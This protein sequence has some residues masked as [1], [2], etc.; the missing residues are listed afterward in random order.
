MVHHSRK[1]NGFT[2][3]E[4]VISLAILALSLGVLLESQASS[5]SYAGRAR[6]LTV[7]STLARS[8]LVDV[9]L[10]LFDEGFSENEVEE[11]GSFEDEGWSDYKWSYKISPIQLDLNG[12]NAMCAMMGA[13]AEGADEGDALAEC[14]ASMGGMGGLMDTFMADL[15]NSIRFVELTVSWGIEGGYQDSFSVRSLITKDD[16]SF[17]PAGALNQALGL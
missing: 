16:F 2:L 15:S 1:P 3:L 4:V 14:E 11:S 17:A 6:D 12:L 7:A 5:L 8:K 10:V 13:G 9:E